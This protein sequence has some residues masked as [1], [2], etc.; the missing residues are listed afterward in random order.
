M[1][2]APYLLVGSTWMGLVTCMINKLVGE[3]GLVLKG[4]LYQI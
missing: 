1:V 4:I 3:V 2:F